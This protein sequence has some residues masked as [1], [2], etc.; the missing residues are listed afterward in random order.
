MNL[1]GKALYNLLRMNWLEDP[2]IPAEPWQVEDL[3]LCKTEELLDRLQDLQIPMTR[4]TFLAYAEDCDSPEEL[5]ETLWVKEEFDEDFDRAYLLLFELWRRF[6]PEKQTLS[7]FCDDL[8][9]LIELYDKGTVEDDAMLETMTEW[10]R[11]LDESVD[12]GA[13]PK[14]V[15]VTFCEF[16]AH[17]LENFLYD[18]I[19][20]EIDHDNDLYAS[21]LLDG[22]YAYVIRPRRFDFLRLR[23]LS[24]ID[25]EEFLPMLERLLEQLR[26]E[27]DHELLLEIVQFLEERPESK[28]FTH[29][30]GLALESAKAEESF[31]YLLRICSNFFSL[32]NALASQ[33]RTLELLQKRREKRSNELLSTSDKDINEFSQLLQN[34]NRNEV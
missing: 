4:E 13:D 31:Q 34:F 8:D 21:E 16:C 27:P 24:Q 32:Q 10:E 19:A 22:F 5:V 12:Q 7:I 20:D 14:I 29:A 28:L 2:S 33:K 6:L 9:H 17:D 3:R 1:R 26:E 23:L 11:L 30:A 15:F 18:L 25:S